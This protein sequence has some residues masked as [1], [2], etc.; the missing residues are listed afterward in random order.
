MTTPHPYNDPWH[1]G[2]V[3]LTP[4]QRLMNA[5]LFRRRGIP[6]LP[7]VDDTV[8][9]PLSA[10]AEGVGTVL[11]AAGHGRPKEPKQPN[12]DEQPQSAGAQEPGEEPPAPPMRAIANDAEPQSH[13]VFSDGENMVH[14][15]MTP[16]A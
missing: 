13:G 9:G 12:G 10:R 7:G 4:S 14:V 6:G 2:L 11:A 15:R 16:S 5:D 8:E 1:S 3:Q